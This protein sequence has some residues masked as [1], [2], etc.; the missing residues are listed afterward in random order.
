MKISR[1]HRTLALAS[2]ACAVG[3]CGALNTRSLEN[4]KQMQ[5][6]Q[7]YASLA[8]IKVDCEESSDGCNQLHLLKGD[9]CYRLA[10]Q[11]QDAAKNYA[12]AASELATGIAQT[13]QWQMEGFNLNRPQNYENLSESLRNGRDLATGAEA[14]AL[15]TRLLQASQDFSRA[16]PG[17]A[18]AVYYQS[19][20]RYAQLR[21]CLL[22]PDKCPSVCRD[23]ESIQQQVTKASG[24]AQGSHC[25]DGLQQTTKDLA[26]ATRAVSCR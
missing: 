8:A 14:D 17:N 19:N 7:D 1:V 25:A 15:N 23:L 3:A 5:Q 11:G 18:C 16:E 9:A 24:A 10:K 26:G 12:C 4:A 20:A 21:T 13:K 6:K 22:H 2:L